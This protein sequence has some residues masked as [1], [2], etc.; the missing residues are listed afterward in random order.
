MI[1]LSFTQ[2]KPWHGAGSNVAQRGPRMRKDEINPGPGL[3]LR[4]FSPIEPVRVPLAVQPAARLDGIELHPPF[5]E[6]GRCIRY[7]GSG[8]AV[9]ICV[10]VAS[11]S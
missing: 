7:G 1:E 8:F 11:R 6:N 3:L 5:R 2:A 4:R 9:S 10:G